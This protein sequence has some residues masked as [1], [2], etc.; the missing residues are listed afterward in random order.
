MTLI[1]AFESTF[2][3]AENVWGEMRCRSR[4]RGSLMGN[5]E[6]DLG[7]NISGT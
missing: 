4:A 2:D 7:L 3:E 1:R 6:L 5:A